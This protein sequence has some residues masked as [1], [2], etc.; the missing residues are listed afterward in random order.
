M[1]VVDPVRT[2][3]SHYLEVA[4]SKQWVVD[5]QYAGTLTLTLTLTQTLTLTPTLTLTQWTPYVL[6]TLTTLRSSADLM[7]SASRSTAFLARLIGL[8][9]SAASLG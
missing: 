9:S 4:G 1:Q 6:T 8:A 5:W 3:Y 2:Y 7:S